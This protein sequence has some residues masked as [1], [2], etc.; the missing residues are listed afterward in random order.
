[1][2]EECSFLHKSVSSVICLSNEMVL[3]K[4]IGYFKKRFFT[5]CDKLLNFVNFT[6]GCTCVHLRILAVT[7]RALSNCL[8]SKLT[9][10]SACLGM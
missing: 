9:D 6:N 10:T 1:M 2:Q 5:N 8:M 4:E 7:L 3:L